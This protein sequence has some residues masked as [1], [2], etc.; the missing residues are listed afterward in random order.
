MM[1]KNKHIWSGLLFQLGMISYVGGILSHIVIGAVLGNEPEA[2]YYMAVYKEKSAYILI[3]PGLVMKVI[4][5]VV[6]SFDYLIKPAWLKLNYLCMAFLA[7]NAVV[8]LVPMMPEVT[9]LARE[10]MIL[11]VIS[12]AYKDAVTTEMWIG[13]SNVIPLITMVVLSTIG[14]KF[15]K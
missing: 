9:Q 6:H 13:I 10:N 1:M 4:A 12:P 15:N 7:V 5:T 11:G 2:M 14:P 3:L 8:L